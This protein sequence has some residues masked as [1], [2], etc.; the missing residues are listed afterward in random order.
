VHI[1]G[2]GEPPELKGPVTPDPEEQKYGDPRGV[3]LSDRTFLGPREIRNMRVVP[4]L[5]FVN[6]CHLAARDPTQFLRDDTSPF[7]R[8]YDRARFASGV[9]AEL[10]KIG[11]RCVV[12]AGWAVND[13]AA[14]SFAMAFYDAILNRHR[15]ID[16]VAEARKAAFSHDG[17]TWGAYQCYGDPNW[18]FKTKVADPQRPSARPGKEFSGI[19]APQSLIL[20]LETLATKSKSADA[21][22]ESQREKIRH[23]EARFATQWGGQGAVAEAFGTAWAAARDPANAIKWYEKALAANDGSASIKASEQLGNHKARVAWESVDRAIRNFEDLKKQRAA[24]TAPPDI[25][26]RIVEAEAAVPNAATEA[27]KA[28]AE[29]IVLLERLVALQPT[30]ERHSLCGSA[31]KR[32]AMIAAASGKPQVEKRAIEQMRMH[33]KKAEELGRAGQLAD[34]FYPVLNY[35]AADL[36]FNSGQPG[37]VVL[38]AGAVAAARQS[39]AAKCRDDPDFW[40]VAGDTEL[41]IYEALADK[42][43]AGKMQAIKADYE[44][45]HTRVGSAWLWASV[46]DQMRFVLPKYKAKASGAEPRAADELLDLLHSFAEGQKGS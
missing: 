3:V 15:F 42:N 24:G 20:A 25:A 43:L 31:C 29:A 16:A 12:A 4:E 34:I 38:D 44:N 21:P 33:Y 35:V 27:R 9:A 5:V 28:I 1:A 18:T 46:Y 6:C 30:M 32:Q 41:T 26:A 17:N 13:E 10:I 11:V 14:K 40:S 23:L 36:V 37:L 22:I 2:H 7:Y 39:L 45:L 8:P 19:A